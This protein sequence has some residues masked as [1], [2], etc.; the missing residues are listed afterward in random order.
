MSEHRPKAL[1][2]ISSNK[3]LPL[4]SPPGHP[5]IPTGFFLCELGQVLKEFDDEYDFTF[6]TPDGEV[7][8]LDINGL[9]LPWHAPGQLASA[10]AKAAAEQALRFDAD[11]YRARRPELT[12]RRYAELNLAHRHLGNIPVSQALPHTDKEAALI[13]DDIAAKFASLPPH[14]YLSVRQLVEKHR[15]PDDPFDLGEFDF[16]HLPGGHAPMVDFVDNPWQGELINTLHEEGVLISLICHAPVAMASAKYRVSADGQVRSTA[17]HPFVGIRVTTV[18][19][20]AEV[21]FSK[22][23]FLKIPDQKTRTTYYVDEALKEAGYKVETVAP[24]PGDIK[25][26]W[27]PTVRV[28]TGDG[29]Q[30]VDEQS[31]V[32]RAQVGTKRQT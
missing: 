26:I 7:P 25:V 18:P 22:V 32:L 2:V 31:A 1:I 15:N 13:R 17:D 28:L 27:E 16:A 19:K 21:L 4:S 20:Y 14:T 5:G 8:Q 10:S 12:A 6:A 23:G 29:P 30:A 9:A 24:N 3:V 11:A